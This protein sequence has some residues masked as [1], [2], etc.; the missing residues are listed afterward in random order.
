MPT[1]ATVII[2]SIKVKPNCFLLSVCKKFLL[3]LLSIIYIEFTSTIITITAFNYSEIVKDV[4]VVP[5]L[6]P[7]GSTV[8]P[9]MRLPCNLVTPAVV[10]SVDINVAFP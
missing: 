8:L 4:F 6:K 7:T 10:T 3:F 5:K 1:M 9:I 2:N